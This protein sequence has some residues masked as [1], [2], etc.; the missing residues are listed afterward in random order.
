MCWA[1]PEPFEAP[2]LTSIGAIAPILDT[3]IVELHL[4]PLDIAGR[5]PVNGALPK[6]AW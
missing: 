4:H 6:P 5:P 3:R 2:T 1:N